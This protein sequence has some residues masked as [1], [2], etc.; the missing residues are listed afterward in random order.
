[1]L[2][3]LCPNNEFVCVQSATEAFQSHNSLM[4]NVC[5]T[6]NA[7]CMEVC[8]AN[9]LLSVKMEPKLHDFGAKNEQL[10]GYYGQN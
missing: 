6:W 10:S 1:M 9:T 7:I 3:V 5:N 8:R 2:A 4:K